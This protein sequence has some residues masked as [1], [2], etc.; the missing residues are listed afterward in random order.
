MAYPLTRALTAPQLKRAGRLKTVVWSPEELEAFEVLK[1]A[2]LSSPIIGHPDWSTP[3]FVACDAC[4]HGLGAILS[5]KKGAGKETVIYYASRNLT[6]DEMKYSIWELEALCVV[7]ALKVFRM[8]LYGTTFTVVTDSS[9][10][11]HLLKQE[12]TAKGGRLARWILA[13]Q[14]LEYTIK[15]RS[16]EQNR[17]ADCLSRCPLNSAQPYRK[18]YSVEPL[19]RG[20]F[21]AAA[22]RPSSPED[23]QSRKERSCL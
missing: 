8:W 22:F 10:V 13:L 11:A 14:D 6:K 21:I 15:H 1:R 18:D 9:A 5:Q 23:T 7:W 20:T 16:A 4:K 19:R 2:M 3:F 17:N 12:S